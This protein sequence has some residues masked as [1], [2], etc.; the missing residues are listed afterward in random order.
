ML[1]VGEGAS[2]E[3]EFSPNAA[4]VYE[5]LLRVRADHE[6]GFVKHY[7]LRVSGSGK[8]PHLVVVGTDEVE[9]PLGRDFFK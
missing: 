5:G 1:Q 6:G 8:M 9:E 3:L 4:K 7:S 2:I